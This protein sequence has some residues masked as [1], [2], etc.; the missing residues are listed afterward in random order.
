MQKIASS[1]NLFIDHHS[2][3]RLFVQHPAAGF[4]NITMGRYA[5]AEPTGIEP[6]RA[7]DHLIAIA[8]IACFPVTSVSPS[9]KQLSVQ[10]VFYIFQVVRSSKTF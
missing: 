5:A 1:S 4:D 7:V 3:S 8:K 9:E 10:R 6:Y 2:G